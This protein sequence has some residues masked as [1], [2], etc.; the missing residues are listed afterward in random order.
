MALYELSIDGP[1]VREA[2]KIVSLEGRGF[3]TLV[4]RWD[5]RVFD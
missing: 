4:M 2:E 5:S 1:Q 3:P